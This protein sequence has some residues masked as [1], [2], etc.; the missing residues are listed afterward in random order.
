MSNAHGGAPSGLIQSSVSMLP[1][2]AAPLSS[3]QRASPR[4]LTSSSPRNIVAT[5]GGYTVVKS[6]LPKG[7]PRSPLQ[8]RRDGQ[9]QHQRS[10]KTGVMKVLKGKFGHMPKSDNAGAPQKNEQDENWMETVRHPAV[11]R[12]TFVLLS[13]HSSTHRLILSFTDNCAA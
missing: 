3:P 12:P 7:S 10:P 13:D 1:E 11:A 5:S 6:P 8:S 2:S 4:R 9:K